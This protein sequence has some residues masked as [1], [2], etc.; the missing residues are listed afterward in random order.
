MIRNQIVLSLNN[1]SS[2]TGLIM[3]S[4]RSHLIASG[5]DKSISVWSIIRKNNVQIK[6]YRQ[7]KMF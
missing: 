7:Y 2:V 5:L 6:L 1:K 3:N 4:D